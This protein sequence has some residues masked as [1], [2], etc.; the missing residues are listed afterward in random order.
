MKLLKNV[1][2]IAE[3]MA[4]VNQCK[5]DVIMRSADGREEFNLKSELSSYLAIASLC[6]EQGD[7]W[8]IFCMNKEDE[9]YMLQ[10]FFDLDR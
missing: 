3:F 1:K 7:T 2:N 10:F 9:P 4:A 8:E 5:G 6:E